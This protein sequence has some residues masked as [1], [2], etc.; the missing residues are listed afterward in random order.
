MDLYVAQKRFLEV[1][2]SPFPGNCDLVKELRL[3]LIIGLFVALFLY[4][5]QPYG[6]SGYQGNMLLLAFWF[7]LA[8]FIGSFL[9]FVVLTYIFNIRQDAPNFTFGKWLIFVFFLI[10]VITLCNFCVFWILTEGNI[11]FDWRS[12]SNLFI[13]TAAIGFFPISISGLII[14]YNSNRKYT[15]EASEIHLQRTKE[16]VTEQGTL[17]KIPSQYSDDF[18]CEVDKIY[19][20]ESQDN[21]VAIRHQSGD[22]IKTT[23]IRNSL[24]AIESILPADVFLR[25]HR[26]FI[27]NLQKIDK[28]DGN[29]QG[30]VLTLKDG[31][32]AIPVSRSYINDLKSQIEQLT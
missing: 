20:F 19:S 2:S 22:S 23:L 28:I 30:L 17:I 32:P 27:T 6:M 26:S 16:K 4:F 3:N 7:G 1:L 13:K 5:F 18:T 25:C 11:V 9:Y 24:S 10:I 29:A 12:F 21:Y 14:Y 8:T 15:Q 31:G